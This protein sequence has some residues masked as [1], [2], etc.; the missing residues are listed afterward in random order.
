MKPANSK[1]LLHFIFEQMDKLDRKEINIY[2]AA[3]QAA[4]AKQANNLLQYEL[5][6]AL[7]QKVLEGSTITIREIEVK[8]FESNLPTL[9]Q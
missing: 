8:N 5:K 6:R 2:E 7:T 1:S 9:Q 4:L 3:A